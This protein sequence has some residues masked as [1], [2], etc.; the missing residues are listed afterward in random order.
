MIAQA[1]GGA[2]CLTGF[3][4]S[5][6]TMPGNPVQATFL[7]GAGRLSVKN[8]LMR[9]HSGHAVS[10]RWD[11]SKRPGSGSASGFVGTSNVSDLGSSAPEH[12]EFQ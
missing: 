11:T 12:T 3:P 9:D 2:M 1:T 8:F 10:T 7:E 5:P 4:G 6:F